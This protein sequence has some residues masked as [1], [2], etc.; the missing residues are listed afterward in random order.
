M[1]VAP[2]CR[3]LLPSLLLVG[4]RRLDN[5]GLRPMMLRMAGHDAMIPESSAPRRRAAQVCPAASGAN[6]DQRAKVGV[7]AHCPQN[8]HRSR[9]AGCG[10][11]HER[12]RLEGVDNRINPP[13]L[14]PPPDP[15]RD[16]TWRRKRWT[17]PER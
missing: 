17:W 15:E 2:L 16:P 13:E 10:G 5:V 9:A 12:S 8:I 1:P 11:G 14:P 4:L 6:D 7:P 3:P